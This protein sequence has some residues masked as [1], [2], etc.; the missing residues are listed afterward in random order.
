MFF[1]FFLEWHWNIHHIHIKLSDTK[2]DIDHIRELY[3]LIGHPVIATT[4]NVIV[5]VDTHHWLGML[6]LMFLTVVVDS[7]IITPLL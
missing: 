4:I 5:D 7:K 2:E 6:L 1:H 3:E